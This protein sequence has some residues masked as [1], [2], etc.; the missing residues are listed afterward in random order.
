MVLA[1]YDEVMRYADS[2]TARLLAS[3]VL[4]GA[5]GLEREWRHKASGLRT[6]LLMCVGAAFFTIMSIH[7]SGAS[8][9]KG[10][11]ASNIVQG[12]GFLG[13]GLI[14]RDRSRLVGL[15]SAATVWVVASIGMACGAG[16]YVEALIGTAIVLVALWLIGSMEG[17]LPWKQYLLLY[18]VRGTNPTAMFG[19]ILDVMDKARLRMNIVD[20]DTLGSRE[21]VTFAVTATRARHE[22]L[23][24]QLKESDT[25]DQ[26]MVFRDSDQD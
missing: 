18:E 9:A 3:A 25:T 17:N 4:G 8:E 16:S 24:G 19:T 12:V 10:Q 5:V 7:L 20:R 13:A 23:L 22:A 6:N 26:V 11:V 15:T 2:T 1:G 21:R 14:M